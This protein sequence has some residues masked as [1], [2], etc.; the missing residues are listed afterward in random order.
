METAE[1]NLSY[2]CNE[3]AT[4]QEKVATMEEAFATLRNDLATSRS[5]FT[6]DRGYKKEEVTGRRDSTN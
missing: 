4:A 6:G 5:I 1:S 2:Y 3:A